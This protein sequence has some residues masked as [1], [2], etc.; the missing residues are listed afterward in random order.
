MLLKWVQDEIDAC[1]IKNDAISGL[2]TAN[3]T[4]VKDADTGAYV[5]TSYLT[6]GEQGKQL[7]FYNVGG[8]SYNIGSIE[9]FEIVPET[10]AE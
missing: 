8:Q 1:W 7:A 5:W 10:S 2:Q 4:L 6:S 9:I 3:A